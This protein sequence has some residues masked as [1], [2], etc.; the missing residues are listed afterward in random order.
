MNAEPR[1]GLEEYARTLDL[2]LE[3]IVA[4]LDLIFGEFAPEAA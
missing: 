1:E 4:L 2:N 3:E